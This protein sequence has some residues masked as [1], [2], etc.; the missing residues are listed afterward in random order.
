MQRYRDVI[1]D[2]EQTG[3]RRDR[4]AELFEHSDDHHPDQDL[5]L[6]NENPQIFC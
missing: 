2:I 5:A 1:F 3:F 4:M 6:N